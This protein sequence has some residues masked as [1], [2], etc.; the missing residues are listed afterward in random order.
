MLGLP[1]LV[2]KKPFHQK[3]RYACSQFVARTL[4]H[5]GI[6]KVDKH[7]SLV[8]PKDFYEMPDKK[9][10]YVGTIEGYLDKM[11]GYKKYIQ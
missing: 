2:L 3:R 5:Y 1:F 6:R 4:E 7:W 10:L 9:I 8:T 11:N